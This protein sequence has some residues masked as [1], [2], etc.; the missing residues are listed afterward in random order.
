MKQAVVKGALERWQRWSRRERALVSA[1]GVC[2]LGALAFSLVWQPAVQRLAS[3]ELHYQQQLTLQAQLQQAQPRRTPATGAGQP[4][5]LR[6]SESAAAASLEIS[7]M[8]AEGEAVRLTLSGHPQALLSWL[9]L[10]ERQG[11]ALQ[12]LTLEK[13]ENRLLA[14][15]VLR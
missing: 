7:Q 4:L 1:T 13:H 12:S 6:V 2:L 9:D 8:D 14:R 11:Q 15:V 3:S 5:P 10:M